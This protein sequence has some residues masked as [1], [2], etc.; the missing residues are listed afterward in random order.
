V[1]LRAFL[2]SVSVAGFV[3]S[4]GL[5][6][7]ALPGAGTPLT[8]TKLAY[9]AEHADEYDTLFFGSS[10]A[11]RGVSPEVFDGITAAEGVPCRS[12][13]FGAPAA[14]ATDVY[15][16]L[17]K[18]ERLHPPGLRFVFVDPERLQFLTGPDD[19]LQGPVIDWHDAGTTWLAIAYVL[20]ADRDAAHTAR[21]VGEHLRAFLY[22]T[23]CIGLA[24]EVTRSALGRG[25]DTSELEA[26]LGPRFDG[27]RPLNS[28][29]ADVREGN[30]ER[31]AKNH[32]QYAQRLEKLAADRDDPRPVSPQA[33]AFLTRIARKVEDLGAVPIFYAQ[34]G[35]KRQHD[36]IAAA[37]E[38]AV[39]NLLRYDRQDEHPELFA[40]A[41]RWDAYHL[42][43]QGARRMTEMLA[44]DFVAGY[45]AGRFQP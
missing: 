40:I 28:V 23:A 1:I 4:S 3:V 13:N 45:K 16:T 33:L 21:D 43:E 20:A 19:M 22:R 44:R 12:F 17:C 14:R 11:Y 32:R 38:G 2:L 26:G 31:F 15:N 35:V 25:A 24:Q 10:R 41:N 9:F 6:R 36:L 18:I 8:E 37:R 39:R 27:W 42:S 30:R 34:P 5:V 29:E 7:S